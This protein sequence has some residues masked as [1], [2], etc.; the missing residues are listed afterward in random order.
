M[1]AGCS[2][3]HTGL[4]FDMTVPGTS[5]FVGTKQCT[6]LHA[7]CWDY[8]FIIRYTDDKQDITGFMGEEW[9]IRY[10]GKEHSLNMK[11]SGLC[12]EE[13]LQYVQPQ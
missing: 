8:G 4:A 3:H 6:W 11:D 2:E 9:H 13:Y 7:N 1:P 5:A 12:L 10:V